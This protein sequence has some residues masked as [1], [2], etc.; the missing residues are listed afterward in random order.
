MRFLHSPLSRQHLN[1]LFRGHHPQRS[2]SGGDEGRGRICETK[3]FFQ[4]RFLKFFPSV[5]QHIIQNA[6]MERISRPGRFYGI[7]L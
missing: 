3:H 6:R 2:L 5:L 4:L 1:F 7:L